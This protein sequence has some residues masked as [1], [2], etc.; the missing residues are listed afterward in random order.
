MLMAGLQERERIN[1]RRVA[2]IVATLRNLWTSETVSAA[3]LMG[4]EEKPSGGLLGAYAAEDALRERERE[5]D[6]IGWLDGLD[7]GFDEVPT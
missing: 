3:Y 5:K 2:S 6:S 7:D 1:D 4:E